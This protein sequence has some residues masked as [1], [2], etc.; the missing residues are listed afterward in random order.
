MRVKW[1]MLR[2]RRTDPPFLRENLTAALASGAACEVDVR[3][4]SDGHAVCLHDATLDRETTGHGPIATTR[5]SELERCRQRG[6]D[7]SILDAAPLFLD[8]LVA[9]VAAATTRAR[10]Q[11][12]VKTRADAIAPAAVARFAALVR[13]HAGA[14]VASAYDWGAVQRLAAAIPG[15]DIGFDPL[16]LYT[17]PIVREASSFVALAARTRELTPTASIYYLEARLVLA[18][19]DCG[20]NLV[21]EIAT[22]DA[23]VDAWTIDADHPTLNATLARLADAGCAQLTSND[24]EQVAPMVAS[25]AARALR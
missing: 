7:G 21:R 16:H 2:R 22:D 8:E 9:A 4:T 14:F 15:L 11:L 18:A 25:L 19:L 10:V 6:R 5:R 1:H 23:E 13:D 20:V 12:D 24:P 3:W 17:R